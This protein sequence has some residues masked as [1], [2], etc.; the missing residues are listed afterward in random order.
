[1]PF[2]MEPGMLADLTLALHVIFILFVVG[3]QLLILAGWAR[4]W[5]WPRRRLFR[6]LHLLAIGFV[7]FEAWLGLACPLTTLENVLR[8]SAGAGEYE[9]GFVRHWLQQ[10]IFYRA[11]AWVFT[12]I[13][14]FFAGIVVLTWLAY[15]PRR[16]L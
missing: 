4:G 6:Q 11:P 2:D 7:M 8:A 15:P 9:N 5:A 12:S 3:G 16:K 13:Y 10:M 1:M 14:T